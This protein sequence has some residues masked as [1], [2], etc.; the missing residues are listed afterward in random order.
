MRIGIISDTH[1]CKT[2]WQQVFAQHFTDMDMIIHAGDVLYHGPRNP[3]PSEYDPAGLAELINDYAKPI[4]FAKG[5]C[6]SEVDA[7]V[8]HRPILGPYAVAFVEGLQIVVTHGDKIRSEEYSEV[9]KQY[10]ANLLITGHTHLPGI[11]QI[12]PASW[13]L[14]PGSPSMSKH[15]DKIPTVA[16]IIDGR[17]EILDVRHGKVLQGVQIL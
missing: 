2:T 8:I 9:A 13:H 16:H 11:E 4:L 12:G 3:I 17:V 1:G 6:D 15:P 10:Q 5:N 7:M 14:N